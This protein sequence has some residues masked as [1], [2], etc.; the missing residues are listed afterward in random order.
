MGQ[1]QCHGEQSL[2]TERP[3]PPDLDV[4]LLW[5]L[6]CTLYF[7]ISFRY[8][9]A[10]VPKHVLRKNL[11]TIQKSMSDKGRFPTVPRGSLCFPLGAFLHCLILCLCPLV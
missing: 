9:Y 10:V 6:G 11:Q 2:G 8:N 4:K 3:S 5:G 1:A 7:K